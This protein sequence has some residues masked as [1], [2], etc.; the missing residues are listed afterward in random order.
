[1]DPHAAPLHASG[2]SSWSINRRTKHALF[3]RALERMR[4][5]DDS[6]VYVALHGFV[7]ALEMDGLTPEATVIAVKETILRSTCLSRF[8]QPTREH[9]RISLVAACIDRYYDVREAAARLSAARRVA[10]VQLESRT[11]DDASA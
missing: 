9:V 3:L 8:E 11:N 4:A 10:H 7:D 6:P 2:E 5:M 1:M